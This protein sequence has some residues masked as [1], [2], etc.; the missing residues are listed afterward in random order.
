[1]NKQKRSKLSVF[2]FLLLNILLTA[3]LLL[4]VLSPSTSVKTVE[5]QSDIV[6]SYINNSARQMV[7]NVMGVETARILPYDF[8]TPDHKPDKTNFSKSGSHD[9]YKDDTIEVHCW[10][11]TYFG[12]PCWFAEIKIKHASQLRRQWSNGDYASK[13]Y[14]YPSN[15]FKSSNG[16][17]GM[18]AD[19]YKHRNY[20]VI[21]Q[22]GTVI[23][24]KVPNNQ[25]LDV[26]TI[27][28]DGNFTIWEAKELSDKV[29]K[30]GADDIMLSFTFGPALVQDGKAVNKNHWKDQEL[31][32]L[33]DYCGRAA[34]GQKGELHY[35]LCTAGSVGSSALTCDMM[36]RVMEAEKCITAYNLDGGQSGTLMFNDRV[37][38]K[39]AY[40]GI[41]RAMSDIIYF[42]SAE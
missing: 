12:T 4:M 6:S 26:L 36:A 25:T 35:L 20:G 5:M 39:I 27:D 34:I 24:N 1:M 38:N 18:S 33:S 8:S 7:A 15:M 40:N 23:C 2:V 13:S 37:Y 42:A 9:Y 14:Q 22:Y 3:S 29:K 11:D 17:A 31:G 28:Y 32:M 16:V 19:F 10:E 21:V 30:D 41:E